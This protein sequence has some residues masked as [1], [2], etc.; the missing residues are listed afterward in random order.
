MTKRK[1]IHAPSGVTNCLLYDSGCDNRMGKDES[2]C[3]YCG[4]DVHEAHRRKELIRQGN[5]TLNK[6]GYRSLRIVHDDRVQLSK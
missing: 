5:L 3:R 2:I 4:W 6:R 1:S